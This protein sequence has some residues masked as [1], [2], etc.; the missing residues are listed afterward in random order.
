MYTVID[1]SET[2]QAKEGNY[3]LKKPEGAKVSSKFVPIMDKVLTSLKAELRT[4]K[5]RGQRKSVEAKNL[6]DKLKLLSKIREKSELEAK[7]AY[8]IYVKDQQ[9]EIESEIN[10][11]FKIIEEGKDL[12]ADIVKKLKDQ[13]LSYSDLLKDIYVEFRS[14]KPD[15]FPIAVSKELFMKE[16]TELLNNM[17]NSKD[18]IE[19]VSRKALLQFAKKQLPNKT[20]TKEEEQEFENNLLVADR[21]EHWWSRYVRSGVDVADQLVKAVSF[22]LQS[23]YRNAHRSFES[24]LYSTVPEKRTLRYTRFVDNPLWT[25]ESEFSPI[26]SETLRIDYTRGD[27]AKTLENYINWRGKQYTIRDKFAPILDQ[28][29]FKPDSDGVKFIDPFSKEGQRILRIK[30]SDADYPLKAFYETYVLDYLNDQ[31]AIKLPSQRPGLRIPTISKKLSESIITTNISNW[32]KM[33]SKQFMDNFTLRSDETEYAAVNQ[34]LKPKQEL[35]LRFTAKHDGKDG[36]YTTDQISL[37]IAS[38]TLIFKREMLTREELNKIQ[39]NVELALEQAQDREVV[40]TKV[41]NVLTGERQ[42]YELEGGGYKTIDGQASNSYKLLEDL[43]Q[44]YLY[45]ISKKPQK[46][47]KALDFLTK[48]SGLN[49]MLGNIAIPITNAFMSNYALVVEAV[50]GNMISKTDL[51]NGYKL[52]KDSILPLGKD[53]GKK[54]RTTEFGKLISY[55]N[56]L[57]RRE[58]ISSIGIDGQFM[59]DSWNLFTSTGNNIVEQELAVVTM[60]AIMNKYKAKDSAGKE[61]PFYEAVTISED[62]KLRL[63]NGYTYKDKKSINNKD[64]DTILHN[65]IRLYHITSGVYNDLDSGAASRDA[66]G[67]AVMF[68]RRWLP[69]GLDAR[70]RRKTEDRLGKIFEGQYISSA[71]AFKNLYAKNGIIDGTLKSIRLLSWFGSYN[72]ETLLLPEELELSQ[73]EKQELIELRKANIKKTL[74]Q[75]YTITV[76]SALLFMGEEDDDS[77]AKYL[78]A[79]VRREMMTFISPLTAWDVLRSPSVVMNQIQQIEGAVSSSVEALYDVTLGDGEVNVKERGKGKGMPQWLYKSGKLVGL[80]SIYQFDDLDTSTRLIQDGAFR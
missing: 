40:E 77:Y 25:P 24:T 7:I 66:V 23:A 10:K 73:E 35:T 60:G 1:N 62:G 61:V 34:H 78:V 47:G 43:A 13:V 9:K 54:F 12:N 27:K 63:K 80:G 37:D 21:D 31:E 8:F 39:S 52:Y 48:V 42:G 29:S 74:F 79:R 45:G 59:R 33:F 19:A 53:F 38:T 58:N 67:R 3:A 57:E 15:E 18:A 20:W 50:G 2:L 4:L 5:E 65:V 22:A 46:Y 56:P 75:L 76:L 36:R 71:I 70:F 26:K 28:E 44:K 51:A 49:I 11:A 6:D 69:A 14:I 17:N 64:I 55:F 72:P 68:M 41:T 32:P 16:A 30:E